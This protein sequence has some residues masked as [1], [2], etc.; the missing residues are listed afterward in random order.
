MAMRLLLAVASLMTMSASAAADVVTRIDDE[1]VTGTVTA[2]DSRGTVMVSEVVGRQTRVA[3]IPAGEVLS[4]RFNATSPSSR[5]GDLIVLSS[6]E[7]YH[8]V[9]ETGTAGLTGISCTSGDA[10]HGKNLVRFADARAWVPLGKDADAVLREIDALVNDRDVVLTVEGDRLT[11]VVES[12][13]SEGVEVTA[14]PGRMRVR[15]D[16]LRGIAFSK[17]LKPWVEPGR[18]LAEVHLSDGSVVVGDVRG[19]EAGVYELRSVLGAVWTAPA[20]GVREIRFRGGKLTWLS[21]LDP[22]KAEV[23]PFFNRAWPWRKD[24]SVWDNPLTVAGVVYARGL[25]THSRTPLTYDIGAEYVRLISD[26]GIDDETR[27]TGTATVSVTG[28]GRMLLAP[29]EVTGGG[30]PRR[31]KLNVAGVRHLTLLVDF[32]R[33][34]DTGDHVDWLNARLIRK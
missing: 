7:R 4:V 31:L 21:D 28:D 1:T 6:G 29:F 26:L 30:R 2:V 3:S 24:R 13:G 19:P 33:D 18:L 22:V 32:G 12:V 25:G 15:R 5:K 8:V 14:R 10:L 20:A 17:T 9:T 23:T 34:Q 27:G 11:G 16:M